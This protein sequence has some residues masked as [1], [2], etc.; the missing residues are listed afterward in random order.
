VAGKVAAKF[1]SKRGDG[2]SWKGVFIRTAEGADVHAVAGG[3]W[4]L[5]TGCAASAT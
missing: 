4:C 5:P 3:R 2:P 1:G